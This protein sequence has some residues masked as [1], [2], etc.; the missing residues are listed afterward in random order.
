MNRAPTKVLKAREVEVSFVIDERNHEDILNLDRLRKE[1]AHDFGGSLRDV[2]LTDYITVH[3]VIAVAL[4]SFEAEGKSQA[5]LIGDAP[6][7]AKVTVKLIIDNAR[8][9]TPLN[10]TLI[11]GE[12]IDVPS[13]SVKALR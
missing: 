1:G 4:V 10:E 2:K 3:N 8:V 9:V 5:Y 13:D 6:R 7:K 11:E 12:V